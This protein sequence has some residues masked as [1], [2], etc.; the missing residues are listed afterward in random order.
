MILLQNVSYVRP[1]VHMQYFRSAEEDAKCVTD[2]VTHV[3]TI[4]YGYMLTQQPW[5]SC[6]SHGSVVTVITYFDRV[7]SRLTMITRK[8][9]SHILIII[10]THTIGS[11]V[12]LNLYHVIQQILIV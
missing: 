1:R 9:T 10:I 6:I 3:H 8:I 7:A 4:G 12:R 5:G 11:V 2:I